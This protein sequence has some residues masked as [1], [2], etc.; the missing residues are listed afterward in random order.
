MSERRGR[1]HGHRRGL[2]VAAV[3]ASLLLS[4]C[5]LSVT[6][7]DGAR[8]PQRPPDARPS[9]GLLPWP[10]QEPG[11]AAGQ[12]S[13]SHAGAGDD[14]LAG[15]VRR[16]RRALAGLGTGEREDRG[17]AYERDRFGTAWADVD[18]NGC[19]QRDDVLLRDARPGTA[20]VEQQGACDHDVLA[21]QW[22]DP[23]TGRLL[24]FDDLKDLGQAQA[25]QIDH[26]V[27]LGEAW[28]SGAWRWSEE[29]REQY[30]NH[31][32]GLL[33]VDGPTNASK[34]DDDPAAWRPRQSYQCRYALRWIQVKDTWELTVDTSERNAL[35]QMLDA[36]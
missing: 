10:T 24:V 19:N 21:G 30:A 32:P 22:R 3:L 2:G 13:H 15:E 36:C 11:V 29:R 35:A 4:S 26:V 6:T 8:S 28:A 34:S 25:I 18:G 5:A 7:G 12:P 31:L 20:V 33:A 16:A 23:Y 17:P 27:P 1:D 14:A 9:Q